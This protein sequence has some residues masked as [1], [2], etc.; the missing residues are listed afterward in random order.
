MKQSFKCFLSAHEY[1]VFK[2]EDVKLAG[3][4]LVVAKAIVSKCK[5]CGKIIV[6]EIST[7]KFNY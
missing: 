1:E 2:E 7:I 6:N 3:T 5:H 4:D